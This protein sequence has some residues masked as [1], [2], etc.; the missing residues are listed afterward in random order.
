MLTFAPSSED[1][2]IY[3][4]V[5][6]L[7]LELSEQALKEQLAALEQAFSEKGGKLLHQEDWGRQGFAYPVEKH[8]EGRYVLFVVELLP[9]TAPSVDATILLEKG[10]LRHLLVKAPKH[11]ELTPFA[12]RMEAWRKEEERQ[13]QEEEQTK[14]EQLKQR[15]VKRA[16]R[17]TPPVAESPTQ[18]Q[19]G[20]PGTQLEEGLGKIISDEDLHL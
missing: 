19:A 4:C 12:E 9:S 13:T 2:R 14:E 16:T 7:P 3:E 18:P 15:I 11:Y 1:V 5:V 10:V 17:A 20:V 8:R 6:L